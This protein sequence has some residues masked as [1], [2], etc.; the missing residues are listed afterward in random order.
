M[1]TEPV[2]RGGNLFKSK[3]IWNTFIAISHYWVKRVNTVE[4]VN[5]T[6]D[7]VN[8]VNKFCKS[9]SGD[10]TWD[11]WNKSECEGPCMHLWGSAEGQNC[12]FRFCNAAGGNCV[13]A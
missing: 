2:F 4:R 13:P 7:G 9:N 5:N 10:E 12:A 11:Y 8:T 6:D 3:R 1:I